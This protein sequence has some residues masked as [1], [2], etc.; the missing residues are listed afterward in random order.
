[1]TDYWRV[2]E[3]VISS[4]SFTPKCLW[5]VTLELHPPRGTISFYENASQLCECSV[6][7]WTV[8]WWTFPDQAAV[9]MEDFMSC[10]NIAPGWSD[11]DDTTSC[12]S[13][14]PEP[15]LH[16]FSSQDFEDLHY[17]ILFHSLNNLIFVLFRSV[18]LNVF[19]STMKKKISKKLFLPLV[20]SLRHCAIFFVCLP[21]ICG[22][23]CSYV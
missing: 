4:S 18:F 13:G 2:D 14:H 16:R 21:V 22:N 9:E 6:P 5:V 8:S 12:I 23:S 20:S 10:S 17:L 15:T 19:N 3:G 1:M 7:P 11:D